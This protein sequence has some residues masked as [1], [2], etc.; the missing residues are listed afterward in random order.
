MAEIKTGYVHKCGKF[1][2]KQ[3]IIKHG[4]MLPLLK[5]EFTCCFIVVDRKSYQE[6]EEEVVCAQVQWLSVLL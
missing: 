5:A 4:N 1:D 3:V 6:L 2:C